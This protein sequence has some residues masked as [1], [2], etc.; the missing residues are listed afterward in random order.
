VLF[1][2]HKSLYRQRGPVSQDPDQLVP[3]GVGLIR[4]TGQ[5]VTVVAT[6]LMVGRVLEAAELLSAEGLSIEVI[7]PR[8]M[9]PL[10]IE[11][12]VESARR[13]SRCVVVHEAHLNAGAGAEISARV[14]ELAFHWLDAPVIRVGGA[15]VPIPQNADL[16]QFHVP[17]LA[18]IVE[19]IHRV[20]RA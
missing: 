14:Q 7:D 11:L 8:T 17:S 18:R 19:G 12:I 9:V 16:E 10:D 4:R 1:F 3:F 20:M 6:G 15:D 5:H 2:E 13:T